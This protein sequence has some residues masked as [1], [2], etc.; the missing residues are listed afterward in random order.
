MHDM[1]EMK[2]AWLREEAVATMTGWDFS[3]IAGRYEETDIFPW[4][5]RAIVL[6]HLRPH[7]QLLDMGTGGGEFLLTLGH[8]GDHTMVT[9]A[10]PPNIALCRERLE[11]LGIRVAA[12]T[13]D[14]HIPLSDVAFGLIINRHEAYDPREVWRML[15]PGGIFITQQVGED[16]DR[17]L[18][19]LLLPDRVNPFPGHNAREQARRF[20]DA[21]F[22]LLREEE[23]FGDIRFHD[24]GALVWF[25]RVCS[26]EFEGFSVEGCLDRLL[27]AQRIMEEKGCVS[28]R[29]HRF[30][31]V[32]RKNK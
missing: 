11:P 30:L 26:W 19:E 28:G 27:E 25:A 29:T 21:G 1:N 2:Q 22:S 32:A 14:A 24:V 16:N 20:R 18:A 13:D 10:Y 5:Y 4:D 23:C 17:E 9:E 31:I 12:V 8:P 6:E 7:M 3:H 15:R